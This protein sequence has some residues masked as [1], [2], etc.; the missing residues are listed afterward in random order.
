MITILILLV[1]N[2]SYGLVIIIFSVHGG[3]LPHSV[4]C[5]RYRTII[6]ATKGV[7]VTLYTNRKDDEYV[8]V[9]AGT[10]HI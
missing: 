3:P 9:E 6:Y 1:G 4:H 7:A 8:E 10:C 2:P 5:P